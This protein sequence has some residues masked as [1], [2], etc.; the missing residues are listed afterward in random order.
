[1]SDPIPLPPLGAPVD[2]LW[3]VLLDL[4]ERLSDVPWSLIGGQMVLLHAL[5]H[6]TVPP[7]VSQDG[8]VITNVRLATG[9][10]ARV[11]AELEGLGF[12]C[13]GMA[14]DGI[15]H[16]Y[17]RPSRDPKRPVV[18]DVLAPEGVGSRT[19]LTTTPPGRTLQ[20]PG[21]SQALRR[22]ETVAVVV[23]DR[24]GRV[25]RPSL[26]G[27]VVGKAAACGLPDDTS[28]HFRD[29]ALLCAL[30]DDPFRLT[31]QLGSKDRKRLRFAAALDDPDH[32]AWALVP[33][34]LRDEGRAAWEI[35]NNLPAP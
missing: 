15:A 13:D 28:R 31:E 19:D 8:D 17:S 34:D 1:M 30:I 32:E 2:E 4:S 25:P 12:S 26:L 22:T 24:V 6:D 27:A 9:G 18:I 33:A 3:D 11:V 16:R 20:V 29:L 14:P 10:L 23:G 7:Q 35:L 5:E 21:G